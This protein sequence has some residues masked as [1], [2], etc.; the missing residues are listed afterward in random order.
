[1]K[2][3]ATESSDEA[4]SGDEF[5][6]YASTSEVRSDSEQSVALEDESE[7]DKGKHDTARSM[8]KT[9]TKGLTKRLERQEGKGR[10]SKTVA[11]T[12]SKPKSSR[13]RSSTGGYKRPVS[14]H[15]VACMLS[16]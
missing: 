11:R 10:K 14:S 8:R 2:R 16:E 4:G 12:R 15:T 9:S 3:K 13:R 7:D 6:P 1:M 5:I